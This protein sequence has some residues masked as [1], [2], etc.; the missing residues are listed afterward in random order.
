MVLVV[1]VAGYVGLK[2][3]PMDSRGHLVGGSYLHKVCLAIAA[4]L[5]ARGHL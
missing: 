1:V 3:E 5:D 4:G 2:R